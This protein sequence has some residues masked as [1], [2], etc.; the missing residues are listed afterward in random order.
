[1]VSFFNLENN[2]DPYFIERFT[3]KSFKTSFF[4]LY[5]GK[6]VLKHRKFFLRIKNKF[7]FQGEKKRRFKIL[8]I[9][10]IIKFLIKDPF[11]L[12]IEYAKINNL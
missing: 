6:S 12:Q 1:M 11:N 10:F 3:F 2:N 4:N 8:K 7:K 5:Y 9:I